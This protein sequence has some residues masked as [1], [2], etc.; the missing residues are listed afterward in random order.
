MIHV[1]EIRLTCSACPEQWEGLTN[2]DCPV[3]V[4]YR[5]GFLTV[6]VGEK[7]KDTMSAVKSNKIL[8]IVVDDYYGL[9]YSEMK[10]LT[11]DVIKFPEIEND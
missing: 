10:R 3:Y 11:K 2:D 9:G 1:K 7:G 5:H 8:N 6:Q 4:R